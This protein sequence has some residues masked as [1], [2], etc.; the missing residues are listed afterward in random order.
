[1]LYSSQLSQINPINT[2]KSV[3]ALRAMNT[4]Y[5]GMSGKEK[6]VEGGS[7]LFIK[8]FQDNWSILYKRDES[9][10]KCLVAATKL[11]AEELLEQDEQEVHRASDARGL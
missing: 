2:N 10:G 9:L 11:A 5:N 3:V 1:M 8:M 7:S 4:F 6:H